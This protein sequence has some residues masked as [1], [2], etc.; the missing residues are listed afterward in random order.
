MAD[1][2]RKRRSSCESLFDAFRSRLDS[3]VS[4]LDSL[5][6]AA[7]RVPRSTCTNC[8]GGRGL[9]HQL[10]YS[11][12]DRAYLQ[13][14][15]CVSSSKNVHRDAYLASYMRQRS[16]R[17]RRRLP[18]ALPVSQVCGAFE[19]IASALEHGER[20]VLRRFDR[21]HGVLRKTDVAPSHR[22]TR[23]HS[24]RTG[25]RF[26]PAR[27][28][29]SF[30][31]TNSNDRPAPRGSGLFLAIATALSLA[32]VTGACD[33]ITSPAANWSCDVTVTAGA[34]TGTG[35]A[36]GSSQDAALS[37]ARM[38]ACSQ[39]GLSGTRLTQCTQGQNPGFGSWS[40]RHSCEG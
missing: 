15:L 26:R 38:S 11:R 33:S 20:V 4:R 10:L 14:E 28:L 9:I 16:L 31:R 32:W 36:T 27:D 30:P 6:W 13:S 29:E 12:S 5:Q 25:A 1:C 8:R 37:Q 23:R 18:F 3:L 39:L 34:R 22:R 19:C 40:M 35:S 7:R 2:G 17:D 24:P 21:F